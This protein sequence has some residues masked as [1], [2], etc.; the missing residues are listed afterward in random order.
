MAHLGDGGQCLP[1]VS[2]HHREKT[3]DVLIKNLK[4]KHSLGKVEG[5][6]KL[7][8][9][10]KRMVQVY[11]YGEVEGGTKGKERQG[12]GQRMSR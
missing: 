2:Y 4:W 5:T 3:D 9:H 1:G 12:R 8:S 6:Q 7:F 10:S 11:G